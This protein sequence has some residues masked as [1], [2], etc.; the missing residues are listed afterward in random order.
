MVITRI[1]DN[2]VLNKDNAINNA[3]N[4][5]NSIECYVPLYSPSI[6]QQAM[7]SIQISS[8]T[9]TELKYVEKSVFMKEVNTQNLWT[10]ELGTQ[11]SIIIPI[12]ILFGFQQGD[13]VDL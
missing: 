11:E 8:K 1:S 3:K 13:R 9:P 5:I 4:K 6:P 10:S 2:A 12:W 7:L